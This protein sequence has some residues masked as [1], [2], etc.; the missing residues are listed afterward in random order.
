MNLPNKLNGIFSSE[1]NHIAL[2]RSD[3]ICA[4]KKN[5]KSLCIK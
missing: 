1:Q 4:V 2:T 3:V 5:Y